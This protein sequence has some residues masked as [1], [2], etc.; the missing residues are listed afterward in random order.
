MIKK[1]YLP[2]LLFLTFLPEPSF[3]DVRITDLI[4]LNAGT[5]SGSPD[6]IEVED[7]IC[8]FSNSGNYTVT[9]TGSGANNNF[10]VENGAEFVN[11]D[12]NWNDQVGT[13]VGQEQLTKNTPSTT[14]TTSATSGSNTCNG[15]SNNTAHI[16]ISFGNGQLRRNL[17]GTYSGTLTLLIESI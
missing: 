15:G 6:S 5:W 3:A 14:Q 17:P 13:T 11:Y 16:Q 2:I 7:D 4:N 10:R 12:V 9:A 1:Y 8:I